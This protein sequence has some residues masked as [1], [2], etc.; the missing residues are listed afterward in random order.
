[1]STATNE[2]LRRQLHE[3]E[4][5]VAKERTENQLQIA[6][7]AQLENQKLDLI[8]GTYKLPFFFKKKKKESLINFVTNTNS[9]L[10][11]YRIAFDKTGDVIV[12]G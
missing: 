5:R 1:M 8:Q 10:I 12:G 6:A 4:A 3:W 7:I 11:L 9:E 2:E